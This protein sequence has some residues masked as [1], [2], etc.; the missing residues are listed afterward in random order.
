MREMEMVY[1]PRAARV[2]ARAARELAD[3]L[4][5]AADASA[6]DSGAFDDGGVGEAL[7][8]LGREHGAVVA[9]ASRGV[10]AAT[11]A[12][13]AARW[14]DLEAAT[15]PTSAVTVSG[16]KRL[17]TRI[18]ASSPEL[19]GIGWTSDPER[20]GKFLVRVPEAVALVA[21]RIWPEAS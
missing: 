6:A 3:A 18:S 20:N 16:R 4:D 10:V 9:T 21:R 12:G 15:E 17:V 5:V 1:L 8:A 19:S 7:S 2:A 11:V 13:D 14:C